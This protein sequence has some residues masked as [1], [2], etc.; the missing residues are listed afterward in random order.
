MQ[1]L[2][3]LAALVACLII[4]TTQAAIPGS[5]S[6]QSYLT[7]PGGARID[8]PAVTINF[9]LYTVPAGG[10]PIWV[11]SQ[12]V[13]VTQGLFSVN[14]GSIVPF[15]AG[16]FATPTYL[17]ISVGIDPEMTPRRAMLSVAY[18]IE[19][20]NAMTL[21]GQTPSS[22]DQSAHVTDTSN[23]HNVTASQ[24][25]AASASDLNS[26]TGDASAHHTRYANT[27]AVA[28]ILA[29][30]GPGS[31]LNADLLD[32]LSSGDFVQ[33]TTDWG[34]PGVSGTLYE[35]V[36]ALGDKYVNEGQINSVTGSMIA[37]NAIT[38]ADINF[39]LGYTGGDVNGGL[40][41][42]TNS[43]LGSSGNYPMGL[44]GQASA[45]PGVF[46]T[47]GVAGLAPGL[48]AGA[49]IL[50]LPAGNKYG[51][52]G[53]VDTG[54]GAAGL[55]NGGSGIGVLGDGTAMGVKAIGINGPTKG[56]LGVQGS[57]NFDGEDEL[58][59]NGFEIGVLG[60]SSG[61]STTDNYGLWGESNGIGIRAEGPVLAG[62]F[63]GDVDISGET[64]T[65]RV[66][67]NTP[68]THYYAVGDGDFHSAQG[69][70]FSASIGNG[71]VY[72][73][74]AGTQIVVAGLHL[75]D[76]ATITSFRAYVDDQAAGDLSIRLSRLSHG[77]NGFTTVANVLSVGAPGITSYVDTTINLPDVNNQL[78]S[79][80][81]RVYSDNWPGNS[82]LKIKGAVVEYTIAEAD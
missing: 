56:Y 28:A 60:Y 51:V 9:A 6:Y 16:A 8:D 62:Q 81:V 1:V 33:S 36:T 54:I 74:V 14:L 4:G 40:V 52:A 47:F 70:P 55:S 35:G 53:V 3:T 42:M 2:K 66:A 37:N 72:T 46:Y 63:V 22:L 75:P 12:V 38:A 20:D 68:R 23:P 13:S 31:N 15:P 77:G 50:E 17:G 24:T 65:D 26:H 73:T 32:G 30:D 10:T 21:Q 80:H 59:I 61:G 29:A 69:S 49:P 79:Y 43:S 58:D 39:S 82:T 44:L 78:Y 48:G 25:G 27:E 64:T 18:A 45:D 57:L 11:E 76:G 34:R 19:A 41:T 71:G 7:D 67:Y 5:I